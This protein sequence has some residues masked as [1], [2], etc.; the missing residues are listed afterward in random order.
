LGVRGIAL[1][2]SGSRGGDGGRRENQDG[3][4]KKGKEKRRPALSLGEL[5]GKPNGKLMMEE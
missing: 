4:K 1:N 5:L 2:E 3:G